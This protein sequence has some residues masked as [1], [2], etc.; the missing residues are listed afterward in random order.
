M[1]S[2]I[3]V[4]SIVL[5]LANDF[6]EGLDP[7]GLKQGEFKLRAVLK[8]ETV[9]GCFHLRPLCSSSDLLLAIHELLDARIFKRGFVQVPHALKGPFHRE[10]DGF[11]RFYYSVHRKGRWEHLK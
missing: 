11:Y 10:V 9:A 2:K 5:S 7:S 3:D 4:D 1:C 6:H 8:A